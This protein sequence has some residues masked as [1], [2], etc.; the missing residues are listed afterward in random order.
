MPRGS[1]SGLDDV[2]A[3]AYALVCLTAGAGLDAGAGDEKALLVRL[4]TMCTLVLCVSP[5]TRFERVRRQ[6]EVDRERRGTRRNCP[7]PRKLSQ[8]KC[9]LCGMVKTGWR[10][11]I[12]RSYRNLPAKSSQYGL[13]RSTVVD[14]NRRPISFIGK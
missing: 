8:W 13:L 9:E 12:V 7:A 6:T 1:R 4:A 11:R 14:S 2:T 5:T 10:R 3:V